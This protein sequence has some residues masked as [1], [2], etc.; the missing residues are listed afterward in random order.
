MST[1]LDRPG[2]HRLRNGLHILTA[3]LLVVVLAASITMPSGQAILNLLLTAS[4]ACLY[5]Y[6]FMWWKRWPLHVQLV[7]V[8]GL[9]LM[10]T[11][12][13]TV[14]PIG[15]YLV[16]PLFFLYLQVLPGRVGIAAVLGATLVAVLAQIPT[17]L[18]MGAIMGPAVS[19]VVTLAIHFTLRVLWQVNN[20]R[21]ELIEQLI[22]TRNELAK[23]QHA[24]GVVAER[25]RIAHEIHDT[26]A[27]G[28]SSIQMLLHVAENEI[29]GQEKAKER[30]RLARQT[31]ADNLQ[32]ARAMIAALQPAAL[33]ERSLD[34]A[35]QRIAHHAS[36]TS[37]IDITSDVEGAR[38]ELP[39]KHEAALLRIAQGA[40]ANVVSH[41][42]ATRCRISLSYG[43]NEVRL[44]VVDNGQ[45]FDPDQVDHRPQGM[46]HVGLGAMRTRAEELGGSLSVE[47]A[48]GQ[49]TAISAAIP[50]KKD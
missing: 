7:W 4:F 27:Q 39:M 20:E 41:A 43:D 28:L 16:F 17:G 46:G 38:R 6:G 40:V 1:V 5:F 29:E 9:S 13:L 23:T 48:P 44:D 22:L 19:A 34:A 2:E 37:G 8:T 14:A 15:V 26:L 33:E 10:W 18:S 36:E 11:L 25:Q 31:A 42:Q 21:A 45:G 35:L 12:L 3:V 24:A 47:S 30:I 49:G 32:E 50:R